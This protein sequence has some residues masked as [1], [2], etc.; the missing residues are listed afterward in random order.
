MEKMDYRQVQDCCYEMLKF[1]DAFAKENNI[2]YYMAGG[3]LLG[4]VRHKGFIPWDDDV[5]L[6]IPR[7]DYERLLDLF[8]NGRYE[9]LSCETN[10]AYQTP[11]AR[12]W[13]PE[14][15]LVRDRYADA[16]FGAF[17]DLFPIDGYPSGNLAAKIHMM[18]L[19][20]KRVKVSALVK[21]YFLP[22]EK[23]VSVKKLMRKLLRKT[24]NEYCLAINRFAKKYPFETSAYAGVTTTAVHIFLERNPKTIFKDTVYFPF[25]ELSLP[26][27]SGYDVYLKHLY[28]D[29]MQLP[30]EEKRI[31]EHDYTIYRK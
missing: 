12:L 8:E 22:D 28:G 25:R 30:P 3:T 1:F 13:D 11:F 14:T 4:A 5:D 10:K 18:L 29:Y 9:L 17:L 6:M 7:P 19:K 27:P 20:W 31:S 24:P 21:Q 2:R 15:V 16:P 23:F 26:A